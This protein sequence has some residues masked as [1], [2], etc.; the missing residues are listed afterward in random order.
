V[1]TLLEREGLPLPRHQPQLVT[2]AMIE[3]AAWVISLGCTRGELPSTPRHWEQ[4][5]DVPPP[6]QGL[7]GAY[8]C[9]QRH[10][11]AWLAVPRSDHT[12]SAT[13]YGSIHE[14]TGTVREENRND[15]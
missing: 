5:D 10:L 14:H 6:S 8:D 3:A 1:R 11:T 9:I 15:R 12:V 13:P 7:Q 2:E 4:W